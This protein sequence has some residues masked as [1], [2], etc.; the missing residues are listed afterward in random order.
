M[1]RDIKPENILL[2]PEENKSNEDIQV[3]LTDFG[4]ATFFKKEQGLKQVLGSPLYMAPEIVQ[5]QSYNSKVDIW[6]VGVI[7]HIMISGCPPFFG[8]TKMEIYKSIV[9]DKP[10]FGKA[11][12]SLS[13]EAIQF[14]MKC[15]NK[16]PKMRASAE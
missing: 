4:F 3:K 9:K 12:D 1:H 14:T 10:K 8:K 7:A 16:D 15:L 6:S 2:C 13:P 11:L 5:E